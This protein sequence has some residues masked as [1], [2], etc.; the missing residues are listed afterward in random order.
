VAIVAMAMFAGC[1]HPKPAVPTVTADE[2]RRRIVHALSRLTFGARPGD[3]ER[4]QSLGLARWIDDQLRA[5]TALDA[6]TLSALASHTEWTDPI[7]VSTGEAPRLAPVEM[8]LPNGTAYMSRVF[9]SAGGSLRVLKSDSVVP[10][11]RA[12]TYRYN[13]HV[14]G[15]RLV[16]AEVSD[17]Q[18]L[19]M[20]TDFW[21]NHF[22]VFD[23]KTPS[24]SS[25]I[26]WDRTVIRRHAFGRF[27]DLLGA[28]AHHPV[29]LNYLDNAIS[30]ARGVNENF[31]RELLELHTLGVDG[32]YSQ[33]DVTEVARAFT[34]WSHSMIGP[35]GRLA[36]P[37]LQRGDAPPSFVFRD[38]THDTGSKIVL[39]RALQA[40]RGIQDG[41]EVL[42]LLARHPSTARFLA[43]K[44]VARFVSDDPPKDLVDRAAATYLGTDGDIRAVVRTIVTS[45]EFYAPG[46]FRAKIK[47]PIELVL[48]TRRV[49]GAPPDTGGE[50]IDD[51]IALEQVPF[52]HATPEGWPDGAVWLNA[53]AMRLRVSLALRVAN[54]EMASIPLESWPEWATL[55]A[56]SFDQQ[57]DGVIRALLGGYE[58]AGT[59][60]ALERV[61][62]GLATPGT[63]VQRERALREL[64]ALALAS[65]EFQRR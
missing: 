42:D 45:D 10:E 30:T 17:W 25:L 55:S 3:V 56:A 61:R 51:L 62:S 43:R 18:V 22:S 21:E 60:D 9:V 41:E 14:L 59:R 7:F 37:S 2:E 8:T 44:L 36:V 49:L 20:M 46:A 32:G 26:E 13:R 47:N 19:E 34:G 50:S 4:V 35:N 27:R 23:D 40:G 28:V 16:R 15:G 53:G 58:S 12:S 1:A 33:Q 48:S 11:P 5:D 24:R 57:R 54:G 31:A 64:V 6:T 29:M 52:S 63:A 38:S 65:P 39:G